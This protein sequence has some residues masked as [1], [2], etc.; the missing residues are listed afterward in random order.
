MPLTRDSIISTPNDGVLVRLVG[1]IIDSI[2]A[3]FLNYL[4]RSSFCDGP[5]A[6]GHDLL[7]FRRSTADIDW[8]TSSQMPEPFLW[9]DYKTDDVISLPAPVASAN[10]RGQ[11][12]NSTHFPQVAAQL[13]FS[14]VH[15]TL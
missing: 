10:G 4:F 8:N 11:A 15:S 1:S 2:E 14:V 9:Y 12:H 7:A 6:G 13:K 5:T 3:G